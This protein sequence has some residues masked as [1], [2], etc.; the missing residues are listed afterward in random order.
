MT[1]W[2]EPAEI[3]GCF[4]VEV[5]ERQAWPFI[6]FCDGTSTPSREARLY[7]DSSWHVRQQQ[8]LPPPP[9]PVDDWHSLLNLNNQTV[10]RV[11]VSAGGDLEIQFVDGPQLTVSGIPRAD[12]VGEP[13]RF[14][15]WFSNP[16]PASS[17]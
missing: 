2:A 15:P 16:Y 8:I 9:H 12:T 4:V 3:G 1:R 11:D 14:T 5:G 17:G 7:I 10:E 13:W 6:T